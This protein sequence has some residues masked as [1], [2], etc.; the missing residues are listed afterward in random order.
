MPLKDSDQIAP[1]SLLAGTIGPSSFATDAQFQ[2]A[3]LCPGPLD[4]PRR[5][6]EHG[7]RADAGAAKDHGPLIENDPKYPGGLSPCETDLKD[8]VVYC[9][10][11]LPPVT[12]E[13]LWMFFEML[14]FDDQVPEHR[15]TPD[16]WHRDEPASVSFRY[17]AQVPARGR[18][19][20]VSVQ[21]VAEEWKDKNLNFL[22]ATTR[23]C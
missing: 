9:C 5:T 13:C 18:C 10:C 6:T 4:L 12:C 3:N 2:P 23:S 1:G 21:L 7:A 16:P 8:I 14:P 15:G 19:P 11:V 17:H 22:P 20:K